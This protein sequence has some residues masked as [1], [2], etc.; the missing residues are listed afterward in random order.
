MTALTPAALLNPPPPSD[1]SCAAGCAPQRGLPLLR[2]SIGAVV[3]AQS[4]TL[5]LAMGL[6]PPDDASTRLGLQIGMLAAALVVMLLLGVPLALEAL[7]HL[8]QRR[9]AMEQLFVAGI[10]GAFGISLHSML[11]GRADVYF[12]TISILLVVYTIGHAISTRAR[13]NA[14]RCIDQLTAPLATARLVHTP[15]DRLVPVATIAPGD[16]VRVLPGELIPV[17]GTIV[18]GQSLVR[19]AAFTGE[20][21]SVPLAASQSVLAGSLCEDGMLII[22]ATSAGADRRVDRLQRLIEDARLRP[23][24]LLRQADRFVRWFL[25]LVMLLSLAVFA[26]WAW[27]ES[28]S[29]GLSNGL[30]VLLVACPCAAGLA[31]PLA[32]WS[33]MGALARRGLVLHSGDAL[34]RLADADSVIFDKTGTLA[35]D[36]LQLTDLRIEPAATLDRA[37][38]TA[39]IAAVERCSDH[40]V[41]RLLRRLCPSPSPAPT[42]SQFQVLPGRGVAAHVTLHSTSHAVRIERLTDPQRLAIGVYIDNVHSAT[43]LIDERLRPSTA[44]ALTQIQRL[45]LPVRIMTGDH[46]SRS[47]ANLAPAEVAMTPEQKHARVIELRRSPDFRRPILVGDGLND[48]A[49]MAAA[50]ASIALATGSQIAIETASATL[51]GGD[52]RLVPDAIASARQTRARIR[53]NLWLAIA[54]NCAGILLA[55]LGLIHPVLAALLMA[56]SSALVAFRSHIPSAPLT[57]QP[58]AVHDLAPATHG[59]YSLIHGFAL[60][61]QMLL[62]AYLASHSVPATAALLILAAAA[63]WLIARAH[64]PRWLDMTLAMITLGGLGMN[65]GWLIDLSFAPAAQHATACC[66]PASGHWPLTTGHYLTW[67]NALMLL[68]GTPA[69]FLLL[70]Q[71]QPFDWRRWCCGGMLLV[72]IPGMVIGMQ[73]GSTAARAIGAPTPSLIVLLDYLLMMLGMCLGML[74]PHALESLFPA[75]PPSGATASMDDAYIEK[76]FLNVPPQTAPPASATGK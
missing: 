24:H 51:H 57:P 33:A 28:L 59:S 74:I 31:T 7:R 72:G 52:L 4:M 71:P 21:A 55:A 13:Q 25:P 29:R 65:L 18:L 23:T 9:L 8:L 12:E 35:D 41:A 10:L 56:A 60:L 42:V 38:I 69:M 61:A 20:I 40:P 1:V 2:L 53:S 44:D 54:Y 16:Q 66:A 47:A 30:A 68:L 67:M 27:H 64:P 45:A 34:E 22:R 6:T 75:A 39:L 63:S 14:L 15:A 48:A 5:A 76:N 73:L 3:A 19:Q 36:T 11:V 26:W 37:T 50:H 62:L 58:L 43:A 46:T 70:R 32:L 17:D 49:A